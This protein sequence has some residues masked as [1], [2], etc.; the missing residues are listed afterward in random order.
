[1]GKRT[2]GYARVLAVGPGTVMIRIAII[3]IT[4]LILTGCASNG[5]SEPKAAILSYSWGDSV[6]LGSLANTVDGPTELLEGDFLGHGWFF[7]DLY[8]QRHLTGAPTG[9]KLRI[10]YFGHAG[11]R[12]DRDFIFVVAPIKGEGD[13]LIR[14]SSLISSRPK[15]QNQCGNVG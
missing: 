3:C 15:L 14:R 11:L 2:F 6:V 1:M 7:A 12:E 4:G 5:W 9:D 13:F 10:K 8:V